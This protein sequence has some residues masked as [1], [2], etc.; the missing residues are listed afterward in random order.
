MNLSSISQTAGREEACSV[1]VRLIL[2]AKRV[3]LWFCYA[4]CIPGIDV[5][6][7]YVW[8][9]GSIIKVKISGDRGHPCLPFKVAK[10]SDRIPLVN[11]WTEGLEY[12]ANMAESIL[13]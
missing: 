10:G 3:I 11:T 5:V 2:S 4:T 6:L 9:K 12:K 1:S 13:P 8:A 7:C